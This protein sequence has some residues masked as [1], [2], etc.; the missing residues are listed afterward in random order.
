V[1]DA[2][3]HPIPPELA[4]LIA[5][6]FRLL[7]EP[8]RIRM[9]DHLRDGPMS[10]GALT[11]ALGTS[12]QNASKHLGMLHAAGIVAREKAGTSTIY[13]IADEGVFTLCEHVCGGLGRHLDSLAAAIGGA[14]AAPPS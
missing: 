8:M 5:E 1:S 2:V 4:A 3:P 7:A 11:E 10:V 12:Q 9:L 14:G 6:R 13:R